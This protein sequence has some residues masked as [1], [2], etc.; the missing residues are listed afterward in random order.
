[1]FVFVDSDGFIQ[2]RVQLTDEYRGYLVAG[3][4]YCSDGG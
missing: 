2:L 4:S 3:Y 1:M